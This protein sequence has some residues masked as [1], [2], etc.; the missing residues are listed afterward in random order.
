MFKHFLLLPF[1]GGLALGII[2]IYLLKPEATVLF[3]YP[4]PDNV[5][6]LTYRD[7]N[8]VCYKYNSK[9]VDCDA[10]DIV[11]KNYPLN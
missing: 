4:T 5:G 2:G 9:E 10:R 8:K 1:L 6:E 3:K 11:P 7:K